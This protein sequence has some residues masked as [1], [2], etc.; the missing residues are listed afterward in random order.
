M[1]RSSMRP[2]RVGRL[3]VASLAFALIA[4]VTASCTPTTTTPT[5]TQQFCTFF[6]KVADAPPTADSAVLVKDQVVALAQT[7]AVTGTTCTDPSAKVALSGATLAEGKEVP[8]E[9]GNATSAPIAAV[10]GD[11]I[12]AG[13]P[14]LDNLSVQALS[15]D[16]GPSGITVRG[17]VAV[18][19]SG[20]TSTIG[21]VG[22]LANLD[23][24]SVSLSSA[25]LTIPGITTSPIVFNGTLSSANG[26]PSLTMS[27]SASAVKI[28]DISV[29]GATLRLFA[30]PVAGVSAT[31]QGS[32]KVGPSTASGTVDVAFDKAGAIISA[33]AS[34]SAHL[35][36][37]QTGGKKI[38]LTG[39]VKLDGN[40]QETAI[41]FSGSGILGD[42]IIHAANGSLTLATNKATFVGVLDVTQGAN[43][44]RFNG[45][46]VWD[47]IT[48]YT[49]FLNLQAGGEFSGTMQDGQTVSVAGSLDTTFV[50][51]Q[52]R[53]VVTGNFK[54]GT[55][56]AAGTAVVETNGATTTLNVDA[57]LVNAGFAAKLAGAI[58]ITDGLAE[59]VSLD[60]SVTG[61]VNLGDVTLTGAN[62][63]IDSSY[64]SPLNFTFAGG[65]Q[66]GSRANLSGSV[67]GSFG[68]N[69]TL[70][71]LAGQ[72][73]GSLNLDSW[74]LLN[75][76][77]SVI[78]S[79]DQVTL[80]GSGAV[81][82]INFPLGIT[83]NG[84]FTSSLTTPAWSLNGSGKFR[85]ASI[86]VASARLS[87]SQ[88]VGMKAT[89]VGFYFSLIGIPFYFEG[90]FYMNP[91]GGCSK[92]NITGGSFL[93]KPLLKTVL[94]GVVGCPVT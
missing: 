58:I 76:N 53:T 65:L 22:T 54:V 21:F 11:E 12:A 25:G 49:P 74:G 45:S 4:A 82:L 69:G 77:G 37:T 38:D 19:L 87:L 47:G 89:R 31:V 55:L 35:V 60:A 70:L 71:S 93:M 5:N 27:A 62:L 90:D 61:T 88:G 7:T 10:T 17:N 1:A 64:G 20:V 79:P 39:S 92:V 85:I 15:A 81:S 46:I 78:A 51:G 26:V 56:K 63:H 50:G 6:D 9:E 14:V 30:S 8:S 52:L 48:A 59:T 66:V 18:R 86:E 83:F 80:S 94:P 32:V 72:L 91:G 29:T 41:S 33:K 67:A 84:S 68:P 43:Y 3:S 36:G 42:Y 16:I 28:G 2:S 34:L 75:F 40:A 44:V 57:D 23:N 73:S 13:E 24:W